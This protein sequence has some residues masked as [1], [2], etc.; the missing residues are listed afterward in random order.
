VKRNLGEINIP[1]KFEGLLYSGDYI[2][3]DAM[4]YCKQTLIKIKKMKAR[5]Y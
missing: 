3:A 2:Y 1:V 5:N 4:E